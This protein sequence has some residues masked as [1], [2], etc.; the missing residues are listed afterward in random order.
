MGLGKIRGRRKC[1]QCGKLKHYDT[2]T[3]SGFTKDTEGH[4]T[5]CPRCSTLNGVPGC[6]GRPKK[7]RWTT[8]RK[9]QRAEQRKSI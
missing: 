6:E 3:R 7:V 4:Y 2:D 9:Q 5:V 8:S 1:G